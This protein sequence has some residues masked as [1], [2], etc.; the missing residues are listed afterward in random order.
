MNKYNI[1]IEFTGIDTDESIMISPVN[2]KRK[3]TLSWH[4]DFLDLE[5]LQL[6]EFY[7]V[8]IKSGNTVLNKLQ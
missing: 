4:M 5:I 3:N 1:K 6:A 8:E 7:K 2:S